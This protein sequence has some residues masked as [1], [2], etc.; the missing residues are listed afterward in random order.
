MLSRHG[1]TRQGKALWRCL[2]LN[3]GRVRHL[4]TEAITKLDKQA[5]GIWPRVLPD[6]PDSQV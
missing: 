4:K 2:E 3:T 5:G 6:K 1:T